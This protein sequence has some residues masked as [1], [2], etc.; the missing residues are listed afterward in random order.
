MNNTEIG[1]TFGVSR[2]MVIRWIKGHNLRNLLIDPEDD[3]VIVNYL[4]EVMN[5]CK[6]LG[7]LYARGV[8]LSKGIKIKRQRL[9]DIL[10][11]LKQSNPVRMSPITR[12][13]YETRTANSMWHLDST[14]KLIHWRFITSGC[15]DGYSRKII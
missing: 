1:K 6:N 15:V 5:T 11:R 13:H 14:H 4:Q 7:E 8:L 10:K 2:F 9:R 12:R 3:S